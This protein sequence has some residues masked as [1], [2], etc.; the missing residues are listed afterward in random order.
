MMTQLHP[1][2]THSE[3]QRIIRKLIQ[4]H[5]L[6]TQE[7]DNILTLD[8]LPGEGGVMPTITSSAVLKSPFLTDLFGEHLEITSSFG[9]VSSVNGYPFDVVIGYPPYTAWFPENY[10]FSDNL[11]I[12]VLFIYL[13][14]QLL[15]T[16]GLLFVISNSDR[17]HWP[18]DQIHKI[19]GLI[20]TYPLP[21]ASGQPVDNEILIYR[22]KPTDAV[23]YE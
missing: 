3:I 5:R 1:I 17:T 9:K 16:D 10:P 12:E 6:N 2:I 4:H 13:A 21:S 14:F 11:P 15:Q 22:K 23:R 8:H 19:G 7:R 20:D 18:E